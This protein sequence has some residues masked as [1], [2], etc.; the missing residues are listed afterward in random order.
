LSNPGNTAGRE[1]DRQASEVHDEIKEVH[2]EIKKIGVT[3]VVM[4][5]LLYCQ[6]P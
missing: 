3:L 4:R 6:M 2:D 5:N 1:K